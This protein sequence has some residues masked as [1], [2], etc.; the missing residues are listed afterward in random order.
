[1]GHTSESMTGLSQYRLSL[2]LALAGIALSLGSCVPFIASR[3]DVTDM[4]VERKS[5]GYL[6]VFT[7]TKPV[8]DVEAFVSQS[9]WLIV[10]IANASVDSEKLSSASFHGIFRKIE[11]QKFKSSV[12]VSLQLAQKFEKAEVV[13]DPDTYDFFVELFPAPKE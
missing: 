4:N 5:N 12:Q 8:D 1:M 6:V 3:Y 13:R 10:T 2:V 11:T 9:D 7:A